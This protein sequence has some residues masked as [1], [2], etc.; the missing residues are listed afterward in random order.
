[1]HPF[2]VYSSIMKLN[3]FKISY[4]INR[5]QKK[6]MDGRHKLKTKVEIVFESPICQTLKALT[7]T[8]EMA[9]Y[10]KIN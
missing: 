1:M 7:W 9:L 5:R 8:L 3:N 6:V 10:P 4:G 2:K